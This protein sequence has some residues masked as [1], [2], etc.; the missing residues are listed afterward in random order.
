MYHRT[1]VKN[2]GDIKIRNLEEVGVFTTDCNKVN[3]DKNI[4]GI[5][6][7]PPASQLLFAP[8]GG[9]SFSTYARTGEGVKQEYMLCIQGEEGLTHARKSPFCMY[10]V[11]FPYERYFHHTL[12]SLVTTFITVL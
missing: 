1:E 5:S 12:M 3:G 2:V 8:L 9:R 4:Q 11:V 10:F 6:S 7:Q